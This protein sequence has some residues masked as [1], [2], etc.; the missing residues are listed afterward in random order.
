MVKGVRHENL[1]TRRAVEKGKSKTER[2]WQ[3]QQASSTLLEAIFDN[4]SLSRRF[5][6]SPFTLLV[7]NTQ[8]MNSKRE[9]QP[10]PNPIH[11]YRGQAALSCFRLASRSA[12]PTCMLGDNQQ[13][14]NWTF[15]LVVSECL[16]SPLLIL[17]ACEH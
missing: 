1:N 3:N 10:N 16:V 15:L 5:R 13:H 8:C 9:L 12:A 4:S 7:A 6:V 17:G 2:G 11:V 14:K